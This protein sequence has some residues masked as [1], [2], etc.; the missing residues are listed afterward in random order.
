MGA[1]D[2]ILNLGSSYMQ[3]ILC[4]APLFMLNYTFTAFV[5]ND[6]SPKIAMT[7]TLVSGVFNIVFD[8]IFMFPMNMG[9]F[10]AALATGFSPIV[11]MTICMTHY[12]SKRNTI[13]FTK[14]LP[15]V[16]RLRN[17]CNLGI[18]AFVG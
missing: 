14:T 1:D 2:T 17:S 5:R 13:R 6:G 10:G 9:M 11:S 3:V 7:A 4:F 12:L 15:S 18:V 16:T 8:Y